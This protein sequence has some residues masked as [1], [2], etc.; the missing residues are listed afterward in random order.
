MTGMFMNCCSC[1]RFVTEEG[2]SFEMVYSGYPPSPDHEKARCKK[3]T[4]RFG[5]L[6]TGLVEHCGESRSAP[7]A[8]KTEET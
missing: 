2:A 3:C 7:A 4:K 5:A 6:G 8:R 1:G